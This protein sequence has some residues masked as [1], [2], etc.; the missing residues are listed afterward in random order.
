MDFVKEL[1]LLSGS[2]V[3]LFVYVS[4]EINLVALSLL[5]VACSCKIGVGTVEVSVWGARAHLILVCQE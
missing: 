3:R 4:F 2:N 5:F 1:L